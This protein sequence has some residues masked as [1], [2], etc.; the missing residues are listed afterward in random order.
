MSD[1]KNPKV[2]TISNCT[3]CQSSDEQR[4]LSAGPRETEI[5]GLAKVRNIVDEASSQSKDTMSST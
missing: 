1:A 3:D 4:R 5:E 2:A